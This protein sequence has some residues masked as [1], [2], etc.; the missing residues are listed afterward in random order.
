MMQPV[1]NIAR[2]GLDAESRALEVAAANIAHMNDTIRPAEASTAEHRQTAQPGSLAYR[3]VLAVRSTIPGG[4]VRS[5]VIE[6][7]PPQE[8]SFSPG[9]PMADADGVVARPVVNLEN[10]FANMIMSR[11]AFQANLNS[12]RTA[13]A[14]MGALL[15][16]RI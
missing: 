12:V 15:S 4:G 3:P 11:R 5:D 7:D 8:L 10:E 13:D 1:L 6:R 9:D 16:A 14:M 2:S